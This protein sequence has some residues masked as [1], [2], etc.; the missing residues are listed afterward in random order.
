MT[1]NI[2]VLIPFNAHNATVLYRSTKLGSLVLIASGIT[3]LLFWMMSQLIAQSDVQIVEPTEYIA[4]DAV[5]QE[6]E[7]MEI[8]ENT[9]PPKPEVLE[10]PKNLPDNLEPDASDSD[11][12]GIGGAFKIAG[13]QISTDAKTSLNVTGGEARPIVRIAPQ[14][15]I[16]AAREGIEGWVILSFSINETGGIEDV[17]V[18]EAEPKRV[19]NREA[20]RALRKWK[21]RPKI[22]EGKP[23]K[24]HN[25]TVQLDF[26]L[27]Q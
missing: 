14:Y 6:P 21:Y 27:E 5:M 22:V 2:P 20:M 17:E 26:K 1:S 11:L 13:P 9:L 16:A 18:L 10:P 4:I 23:V 7:E 3:L 24:Q 25:I 19:F 15:P 12:T 8:I